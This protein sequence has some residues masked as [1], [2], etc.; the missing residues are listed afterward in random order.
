M[1]SALFKALVSHSANFRGGLL[2]ASS[3]TLVGQDAAI[4]APPAPACSA[5]GREAAGDSCPWAPA[6][7]HKRAGQGSSLLRN[8]A[9][10]ARKRL[11][12][13]GIV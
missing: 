4:P 2:L 9:K 13:G 8:L 11:G 6:K 12:E 5:T 7:P 10:W 3:Q 1:P